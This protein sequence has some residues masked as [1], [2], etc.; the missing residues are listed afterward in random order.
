MLSA[1]RGTTVNSTMKNKQFATHSCNPF[2]CCY[3]HHKDT[4]A[5]R[6]FLICLKY[7]A[8]LPFDLNPILSCM[9][10]SS[11]FKII[12]N[13]LGTT[14]WLSPLFYLSTA[15]HIVHIYKGNHT[16]IYFS[17]FYLYHKIIQAVIWAVIFM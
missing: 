6:V 17:K 8:R 14:E 16:I 10:V 2:F 1:S 9:L 5:H 13:N 7:I 12:N 11:H 4:T 15:Q 3:L